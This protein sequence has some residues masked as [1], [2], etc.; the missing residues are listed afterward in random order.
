VRGD[1]VPYAFSIALCHKRVV[2]ERKTRRMTHLVHCISILWP[3]K[4]GVSFVMSSHFMP[5]LVNQLVFG[6]I[7]IGGTWI[8]NLAHAAFV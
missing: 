8:S 5:L 1:G 6:Q 7:G 4:T 3:I 2:E